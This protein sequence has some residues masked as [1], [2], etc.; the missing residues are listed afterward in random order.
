[1]IAL[2]T[3]VVVRLL[4]N[5]DA[6]QAARARQLVQANSVLLATTVLLEC[7]WVL[8]SAYGFTAGAISD[9]LSKLIRLP[10]LTLVDATSVDAALAAYAKGIDFADALHV[11]A[12]RDAS[13]FA[14]F[15][16]TL[17]RRAAAISGFLPVV[18]P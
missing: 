8:R 5:D 15:D 3:N 11:E 7:E 1:M 12:S 6:D 14:T 10:Q 9:A 17:Q 16:R 4:V 18:E 13:A 2:D